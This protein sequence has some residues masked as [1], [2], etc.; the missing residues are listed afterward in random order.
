[1]T[2]TAV[3][4]VKA[5]TYGFQTYDGTTDR[6]KTQKVYK[7]REGAM[8]AW[9]KSKLSGRSKRVVARTYHMGQ[10]KTVKALTALG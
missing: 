5:D 8:K 1:M 10:Y 3:P 2:K 6:W 4:P 7:T 9:R